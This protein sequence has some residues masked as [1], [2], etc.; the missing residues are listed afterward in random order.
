[1]FVF[2][3][4]RVIAAARMD[5]GRSGVKLLHPQDLVEESPALH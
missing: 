1:V 5:L 2:R 4:V 3:I